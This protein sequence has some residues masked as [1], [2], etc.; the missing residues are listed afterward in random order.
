[1]DTTRFADLLKP[2]D[3]NQFKLL[4]IGAGSIGSYTA[5]M[6]AKMGYEKI[7]VIDY[8]TV[9]TENIAPQFFK[10][11]QIGMPKVEAL[12]QN[13]LEQTATNIVAINKKVDLGTPEGIFGLSSLLGPNTLLICAV[14]SM[15]V[16]KELFD[17]WKQSSSLAFFDAR[18]AIQFLNTYSIVKVGRLSLDQDSFSMYENTLFSDEN[19]IQEPC[20]NKAIAFTS[21]IAGG[22]I[23]KSIMELTKMYT[24]KQAIG[25]RNLQF[26]IEYFDMVAHNF[27]TFDLEAR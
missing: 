7:T 22:V 11:S 12:R 23:S 19:A 26:S 5:L 24:H 15:K 13:I 6:L 3:L 16:R 20:T 21:F 14:D 10:P 4:I 18:M 2:S 1:M 9:D 27:N 25:Y 8:D 17:F